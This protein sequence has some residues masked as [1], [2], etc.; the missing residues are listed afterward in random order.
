MDNRAAIQKG[1]DHLAS[2]LNPYFAAA[3]ADDLGGLPWTAVL[4]ELDRAKGYTPRQHS[5]GDL[6]AQLRMLTERLGKLGFPFDD[7]TR[8]VSVLGGELRIVR[9]KWAHNDDFSPLDVWRA[10]DFVV[11][12]LSHLGDHEGTAE[13][14]AQRNDALTHVVADAG[15]STARSSEQV[16]DEE[17]GEYVEPDKSVLTRGEGTQT[18]T[19]GEQRLEFEPWVV[20]PV[21]DIAV[22]DALP[23]KVA[24]EAVRAVAAEIVEYEGPIQI[25]RLAS[26]TAHSFG[27]QRLHAARSKKLVYQITQLG[28]QIDDK[29]VWPNH[30]DRTTWAEFR[31]NTSTS[32]RR[33]DEVSPVEIVNAAVFLLREGPMDINQLESAVLQTFGR[34]RRTKLIK[35]HLQKSLKLAQSLGV[36]KTENYE[37]IGT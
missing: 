11:R 25:D 1:L 4:T 13:V 18:P 28:Y 27:M 9:N 3:L 12:L 29:F 35:D 21:G 37:Y 33:F 24:K 14:E 16:D 17:N 6:Q 20:V 36:L 22:L 5:T 19:I 30:I 2:R 34:K 10:L 32:S 31:P 23:K 7:P 15:L 8:T 26:L